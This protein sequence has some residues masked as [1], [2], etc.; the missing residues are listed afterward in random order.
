MTR[1]FLFLSICILAFLAVPER[2]GAT[3]CA[4]VH[5]EIPRLLPDSL[6]GLTPLSRTRGFYRARLGDREVFVKVPRRTGPGLNEGEWLRVLNRLG[7]GPRLIGR[8][9]IQEQEAWVMEYI[10][11]TNTQ[12]PL[13][14]PAQVRLTPSLIGQMRAQVDLLYRE[15]IWPLDLQFL[16]TPDGRAVLMDP[17]L[18]VLRPRPEKTRAEYDR[19]L[20]QII[21]N[22]RLDDRVDP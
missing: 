20:D 16:L 2:S 11:G 22:W 10:R 13:A 12:F 18:F 4:L 21:M 17:E 9:R 5:E 7:L 3:I 1:T 19:L 15:G 6:E 8:A 14:A